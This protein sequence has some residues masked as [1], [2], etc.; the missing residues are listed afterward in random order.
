MLSV[1][2][3]PSLPRLCQPRSMAILIARPTDNHA[4]LSWGS[5]QYVRMRIACMISGDFEPQRKLSRKRSSAWESRS[6]CSAGCN[7]FAVTAKTVVKERRPFP[8]VSEGM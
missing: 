2:F 8:D 3:I 1:G 4:R 5:F 7:S 6:L